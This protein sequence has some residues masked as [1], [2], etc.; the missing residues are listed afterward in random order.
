MTPTEQACFG[1]LTAANKWIE[2]AKPLL[3]RGGKCE[4]ALNAIRTNAM[5]HG[6]AEIQLEIITRI[7]DEALT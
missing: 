2:E 3:E 4:R 1:A 6:A 7:A 5:A